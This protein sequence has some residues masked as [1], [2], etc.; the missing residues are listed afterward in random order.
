MSLA[1]RAEGIGVKNA[2]IAN[3]TNTVSQDASGAKANPE[4]GAGQSARN[5]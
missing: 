3:G 2:G 1:I 5:A 4:N